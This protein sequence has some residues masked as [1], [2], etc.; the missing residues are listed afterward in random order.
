MTHPAP[1][2]R[3]RWPAALLLV[4]SLSGPQA[5]RAALQEEIV[6]LPSQ[7]GATVPWLHS[8]DNAKPPVAV[9]VLFNGGQGVVGLMSRGIP[10]P[11]ANFL[12]RTRGLFV[13]QGVAT[14][15]I[16][17]PSDEAAMPDVFRMSARHAQDVAAL[18]A[19]L[20]LSYPGLPVHLVGT[21]RGTISAAY[22]GAALGGQVAGVV[23][24]SSVFNSSKGGTGL[25]GFD[26]KRIQAPLLL[27]HHVDDAC[28]VTPYA[29]AQALAG[30]YPL[31][32]VRGGDAPRSDP[33]EAFAAHGYLGVEAPT[34]LAITQWIKGEA[35][36]R[37]VP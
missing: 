6:Q 20:K 2:L 27:V 24:T 22:T 16:D 9:A 7:G 10:R 8:R 14:A 19:D 3:R 11:G 4:A 23:L 32:S 26:F 36:A 12:V 15:V 30:S 17:T 5:A 13:A 29:G 35:F 28:R 31:I 1:P 21:S 18:V 25:A 34:V 37:E 33:C